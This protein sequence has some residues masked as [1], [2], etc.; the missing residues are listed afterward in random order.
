MATASNRL[1][2]WLR[3]KWDINSGDLDHRRLLSVIQ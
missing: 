2:A 3:L 1:R